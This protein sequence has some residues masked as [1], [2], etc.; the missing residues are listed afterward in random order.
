MNSDL[1]ITDKNLEAYLTY[2]QSNITMPIALTGREMW[3]F[4]NLGGKRIKV[5]FGLPNFEHMKLHILVVSA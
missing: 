1:C 5:F 2:L 3:F 4:D